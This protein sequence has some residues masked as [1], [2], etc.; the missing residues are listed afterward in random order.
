MRQELDRE[1]A[2]L[3]FFARPG[4]RM[5]ELAGTKD[6][7]GAHA[8]LAVDS[9][10]GHAMLMA[11]G[12]PQAPAGKAYQLWF[13]AGMRPIPGRVFKPDAAGNVMLDDQL[14]AAAFNAVTF[15][16]T[17]EPQNGVPAPTGSMYLLTPARTPS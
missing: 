14:P 5:A 9:K 2:A 17:L 15:A 3:E 4:M 16:V 11:K 6:A 7:P 13:I 10:S 1:Q 8:M 12:L